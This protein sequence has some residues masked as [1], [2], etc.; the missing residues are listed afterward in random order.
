VG[1]FSSKQLESKEY[2]KLNTEIALLKTEV[3]Q[4]KALM[5]NLRGLVNRKLYGEGEEEG[6][7][8][9]KRKDFNTDVILPM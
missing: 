6:E 1:L 5:K 4:I 3:E 9:P 8:S 7:S 2:V